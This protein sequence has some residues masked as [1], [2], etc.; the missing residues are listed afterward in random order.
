VHAFLGEGRPNQIRGQLLQGFPL[1]WLDAPAGK[2]V[3]AGVSPTIEYADELGGDLFL[4]QEHG[5]HLQA[6][7]LL[8]SLQVE[9]RSQVR[10]R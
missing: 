1:P 5:E 4:A 9:L 3:E 7:E 10:R 2:D 6:E 8:Q